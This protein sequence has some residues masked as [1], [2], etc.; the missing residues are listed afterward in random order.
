MD[1]LR[2]RE[3]YSFVTV[4]LAG[5][6]NTGRSI[7]DSL[8]LAGAPAGRIE[9]EGLPFELAGGERP[10]LGVRKAGESVAGIPVDRSAASLL[11]LHGSV[12]R[13]VNV[14]TYTSN[15]R[16]DTAELL[17]WYRI[18]WEDGLETSVP[19]SYGRNISALGGG[20][21]DQVYFAHT[22]KLGEDAQGRPLLAQALEWVNPRPNRRVRSVDLVGADAASGAWPLLL[23]VTV[24][25]PP[26]T[27]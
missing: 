12:G 5:R 18:T 19:I 7:S 21:G 6:G 2:G 24:V 17:G 27:R 23:G 8:S 14:N 20:Y 15:Y 11:L 9:S 16:E 1:L 26:F 22:V 13:G 25:E 4:S 10:F 3:G